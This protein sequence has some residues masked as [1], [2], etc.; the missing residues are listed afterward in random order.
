LGA[1]NGAAR[2]FDEHLTVTTAVTPSQKEVVLMIF[3]ANSA[4]ARLPPPQPPLDAALTAAGP[5]QIRVEAQAQAGNLVSQLKPVYPPLAKMARVQGT[6]RFEATIAKDGSVGNLR[7]IAGP[8]LLVQ[9]AMQAA[10][11]WKYKP[12]LLNGQPVE[13]LTT[14]DINFTLSE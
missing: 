11:Q 7:L 12:T 4:P 2:A 10:Q 14:I 8:P 13:V 6:V 5:G 3:P 1:V 9:A